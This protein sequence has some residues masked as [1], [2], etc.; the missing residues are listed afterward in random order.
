MKTALAT[1]CIGSFWNEMADLTHPLMQSY[2]KKINSEFI[3]LN[4][5]QI[6]EMGVSTDVGYE[7]Y[8]LYN[9]LKTYE[10]VIF[11]DTDI[12]IRK[13][14]P[15]LFEIVPEDSLG[16]FDESSYWI[17]SREID[18]RERILGIQ[19]HYNVDLGWRM[20]YVNTGVMVLSQKHR[21]AFKLEHG[22][23]VDL[24]EQSQLNFNFKKLGFWIHDIGRRFNCMDFINPTQRFDSY[25]L[26]YA[27][28]GFTSE[29]H[30]LPLK[31]NR[32]KE[33][34]KMLNGG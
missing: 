16:A 3:I 28:K 8:Q 7:K 12:I 9:L 6:K 33:D 19:K 24:R 4:Y 2:S 29:W 17:Y 21:D 26:H 1:L 14:C 15:N 27:G 23:L 22:T 34:L 18:H 32:M 30:N 25:I 5:E 11:L 13:N 10:R 31:I 20:Q